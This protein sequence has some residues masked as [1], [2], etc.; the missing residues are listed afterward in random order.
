M[1]GHKSVTSVTHQLE[2]AACWDL[3]FH[4]DIGLSL[5][6]PNIFYIQCCSGM[7]Q[8]LC[9]S[10]LTASLIG[11]GSTLINDRHLHIK[12]FFHVFFNVLNIRRPQFLNHHLTICITCILLF[13]CFVPWLPIYMSTV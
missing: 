10:S 11:N 8:S 13:Y 6:I 1:R 9:Y 7:N 2:F 4:A 3:S 5:C 12:P